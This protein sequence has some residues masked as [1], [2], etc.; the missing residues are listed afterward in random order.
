MNNDNG[1]SGPYAILAKETSKDNIIQP[2]EV[3]NEVLPPLG[4]SILLCGKSGSGK[5][6]LLA[7]LINDDNG[8]FYKDYFSKVFLFSPTGHGDDIQSH[9]G[10]PENHVFTDLDEAPE[11]L[12]LI[13]KS[14]RDK[15]KK[16]NNAKTP[17][18][19]VVF[20]DIIGDTKFM[21]S[22]QFS[23]CFYMCRHA[24]VTTFICTQHYKR[25]PR[26]CRQQASLI[27]FFRCSRNEVELIAEEFAPPFTSKRSFMG[28]IDTATQEPFSFFTINMKCEWEKRF[29]KNLF[30]ILP[31]PR[32]QEF[33]NPL[34]FSHGETKEESEEDD[35]DDGIE[36]ICSKSTNAKYG[37][38]QKTRRGTHSRNN[39]SESNNSRW[40]GGGPRERRGLSYKKEKQ[41]IVY[42]GT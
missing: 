25:V 1:S 31:I 6:T 23:Q 36:E 26:I 37:K 41:T 12:E 4:A 2:P 11:L 8:R 9:Y 21:N 13:I 18:Y 40:K 14:Q 33:Y 38:V 24:N 17:Q 28:M 27:C 29:R 19:A 7:S 3:D 16:T 15:I 10:I 34:E 20:D 32:D 5:S 30:P 22:K 35:S 42:K 39:H